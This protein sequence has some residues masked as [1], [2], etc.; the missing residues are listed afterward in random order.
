MLQE[1]F[2]RSGR[3]AAALEMR[4]RAQQ[5]QAALDLAYA[6]EPAEV[7][8]LSHKRAKVRAPPVSI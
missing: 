8:M 4:M 5:W 6:L 7:P 1:H 3:P 2:L